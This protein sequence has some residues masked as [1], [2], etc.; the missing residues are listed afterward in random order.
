ML[1]LRL[2][3]PPRPGKGEVEIRKP[4]LLAL[5]A[6]AVALGVKLAVDALPDAVVAW[7]FMRPAARL[8]ALYWN[9][10]FDAAQVAIRVADVTLVVVR[11]CSATDF[12]SMTFALLAFAMPIP[13]LAL[14]IPVSLALAWLVAV[15]A[16]AVR[17]VLLVYMDGFLPAVRVPA[18]HMSVGIAVFLPAFAMLWYTFV[19]GAGCK[20]PLGQNLQNQQD[21]GKDDSHGNAPGR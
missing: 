8:A 11:A 17:L 1:V 5:C 18:V 13:R 3:L 20:R 7:A 21:F 19:A 2:P 14:R 16:N 12:F 9:A 6:V 10:D 4:A 15:T